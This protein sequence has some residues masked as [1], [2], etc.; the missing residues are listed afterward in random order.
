M[1]RYAALLR[2]ISPMNAKMP[3]LVRAFEAAGFDEVSTVISSGNVVFSARKAAHATLER[4]AERAMEETLGRSFLTIVR[5]VP[6]LQAL[7]DADPFRKF[8]LK[9]GEKRVVTFL[10]EPTK[11]KLKLPISSEGA[12]ILTATATEVYTVYVE[13]PAGGAFMRV[14]EGA[15]GEAVTTRTWG[16]IEKVVKRGGLAP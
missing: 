11:A 4:K 7:L 5:P 14:I 8:R 16:T 15:Y 12:R 10:R 13:G 1:A 6:E 2:G 9:P 3:D